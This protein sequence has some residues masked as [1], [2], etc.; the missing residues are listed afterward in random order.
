MATTTNFNWATPDDS[1]S[2]KD[3]ASAIRSLGTAIDTSLVDLKGGTTGQV[4]SKATNTDMDFSWAT[5]S[6]GGM[7]LLSTTNLS[8][9]GSVT[10]SSINSTYRHLYIDVSGATW[11]TGTQQITFNVNNMGSDATQTSISSVDTVVRREV[12]L[13]KIELVPGINAHQ[14]NGFRS[15]IHIFDYA[16]SDANRL[17]TFTSWAYSPTNYRVFNGAYAWY[18]GT[19]VNSIT[20]AGLQNYT[21]SAGTVKVWGI[22]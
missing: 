20:I 16:N 15:A 12:G 9:S 6:S 10:V 14:S 18:S 21:F 2:V 19:A 11:G 7:T 8:G 1:A 17:G 3:G 4:L 5:S 22:K 13:T